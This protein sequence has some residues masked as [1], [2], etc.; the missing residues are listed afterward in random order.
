MKVDAAFVEYLGNGE[1]LVQLNTGQ[2]VEVFCDEH[3]HELTPEEVTGTLGAWLEQDTSSIPADAVSLLQ[4]VYD[5]CK[6]EY[7]S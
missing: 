3:E 2:L 5:M 1:A 7:E 4:K 6:K